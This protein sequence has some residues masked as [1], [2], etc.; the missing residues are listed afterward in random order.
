MTTQERIQ[1]LVKE[2][3]E[4]HVRV[5][6]HHTRKVVSEERKVEDSGETKPEETVYKTLEEK[7][8]LFGSIADKIEQ[9]YSI[10]NEKSDDNYVN[11]QRVNV[12]LGEIGK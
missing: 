5:N 11:D 10:K 12:L 2:L 4:Y 9:I 7:E 8:L 6:I 1:E 3:H